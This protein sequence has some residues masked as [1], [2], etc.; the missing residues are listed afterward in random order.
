M[1]LSRVAPGGLPFV[2]DNAPTDS[3][4]G[5]DALSGTATRDATDPVSLKES[6]L[7]SSRIAGLVN[8]GTP[9]APQHLSNT[10]G[11]DTFSINSSNCSGTR[12]DAA[13]DGSGLQNDTVVFGGGIYGPAVQFSRSGLDLV[14]ST[15]SR[16]VGPPGELTIKNFF[17]TNSAIDVFKFADGT[18]LSG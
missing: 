13:R 9:Q 4:D 5:T 8:P 11:D 6:L 17:L 10:A 16:L 14:V 12:I 15:P 1:A 7:S 18:A 3:P 2:P